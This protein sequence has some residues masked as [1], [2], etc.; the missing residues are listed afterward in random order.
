MLGIGG[1]LVMEGRLSL[2]TLLVFVGLLSQLF[3]PITSLSGIATVVQKAAGALDRMLD[4]LEEPAEIAEPAP[5][6]DWVQHAP[7]TPQ[8]GEIV[9]VTAQVRGP[10]AAVGE[11]LLYAR[12]QGR[13]VSTT[14]HDA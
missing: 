1:Y 10:S 5:V 13:F 2:G 7:S 12:A 3:A 8:P 14:M 9:Q 4:L 6:I 11:V